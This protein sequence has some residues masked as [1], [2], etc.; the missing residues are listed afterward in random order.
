MFLRSLHDRRTFAPS[1][2]GGGG[3]DLEPDP[4]KPTDDNPDDKTTDDDPTATVKDDPTAKNLLDQID[5]DPKPEPDDKTTT[6]DDPKP[7]D[8]KL[9]FKE[10]P[11]WLATQ[12]FDE[13][14]GE[15]KLEELSKSQ[16]D[17][18][19]TIGKGWDKPPKDIDGY[20][21]E[22]SD[23][24]TAIEK[25]ALAHGE[26]GEMDPVKATFLKAMLDEGIPTGKVNAIYKAMLNIVGEYAPDPPDAKKVI[27]DIGRNGLAV[28]TNTKRHIAHLEEIGSLSED[29]AEAVRGWLQTGTDVRA[30]QALRDRYGD[31]EID[32]PAGDTPPSG[33][34]SRSELKGKLADLV[35]RSDAGENV[36]AE[37]EKLQ[38]EYSKTY[39]DEPAGSSLVG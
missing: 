11:D 27:A 4:N 34:P 18:R 37:H 8:A 33:A 7:I 31:K 29:E 5:D 24:E 20:E 38:A 17:L 32:I 16:A 10:K 39:G 6:D 21:F 23:S 25:L 22:L 1:D 9:T 26:E 15:V 35:K 14:T 30:Y 13:K 2:A 28:L 12:F 36:Q 3:T 19:K